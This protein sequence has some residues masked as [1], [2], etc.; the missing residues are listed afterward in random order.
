MTIKEMNIGD[1]ATIS[2]TVTETDVYLFAGITGDLNPAHTNEEDAKN[3]MFGERI[4]HGM[5]SAG[6][7]SA[8]LGMKLPGPGTIYLGQE[9]KFTKPVKFHDTITAT[10]TV[11]EMIEEKNIVKIE[12]ICTNQ[13]GEV[14]VKGMATAM[15]PKQ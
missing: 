13:H 4:A 1:Y 2:K 5:L 8:V 7:I 3:G 14:V 10:C 12:T 6:F 11:S 9:L 15:P